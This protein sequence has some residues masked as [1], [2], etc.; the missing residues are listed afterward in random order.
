MEGTLI[1]LAILAIAFYL[2]IIRPQVQRGKQVRELQA[3]LALGDE[4]VTIG[5][6]HARIV[7]LD[8]KTVDLRPADGVILTFDRNS[9]GRKAEAPASEMVDEVEPDEV[10]PDEFETDEVERADD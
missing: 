10:E 2:L 8:D 4:V 9:V 7:G 6:M 1:Y 5:G 3:S